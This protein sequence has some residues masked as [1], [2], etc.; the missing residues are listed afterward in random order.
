MF[1]IFSSLLQAESPLI[2]KFNFEPLILLLGR[3]FQ[4]RDDYMNLQSTEYG[5]QKGF[6]KDLDEGKYSYPVVHLLAHKP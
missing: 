2:P 5:N 1:R 4:I 3:F 6:C